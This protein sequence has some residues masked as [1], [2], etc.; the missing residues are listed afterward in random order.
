MG[1]LQLI[2]MI[3]T[4][5]YLSYLLIYELSQPFNHNN[6]HMCVAEKLA[7]Y[8]LEGAFKRLAWYGHIMQ[9]DDHIRK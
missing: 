5:H 9:R 8:S 3:G 1:W 6:Q 7:M 2:K 4:D